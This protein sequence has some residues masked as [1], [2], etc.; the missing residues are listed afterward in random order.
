MKEIH[1]ANKITFSDYFQYNIKNNHEYRYN[2]IEKRLHFKQSSCKFANNI[3]SLKIIIDF[4]C[5]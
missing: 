3:R 5:G 1:L 2:H 4:L